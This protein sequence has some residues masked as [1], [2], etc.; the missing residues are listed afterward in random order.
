MHAGL[1]LH[2][3]AISRPFTLLHA[4]CCTC[5]A[6][7]VVVAGDVGGRLL[8]WSYADKGSKARPL[9]TSLGAGVVVLEA[10]PACAASQQVSS[11]QGVAS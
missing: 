11:T 4:G 9:V 1:L 3:C 7:G 5:R 8:C 2:S 10:L 6:Q